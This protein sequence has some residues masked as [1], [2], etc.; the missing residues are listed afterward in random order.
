LFFFIVALLP[1][2]AALYHSGF[3]ALFVGLI[4][5]LPCTLLLWR[6][7]NHRYPFMPLG[8]FNVGYFSLGLPSS[9]S[10]LP[11]SFWGSKKSG[12]HR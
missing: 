9:H 7:Y 4:V 5:S 8:Q 12:W 6:Y 2:Y 11:G 3:A 10:I 1:N